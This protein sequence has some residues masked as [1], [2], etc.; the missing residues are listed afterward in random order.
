MTKWNNTVSNLK[1]KKD[2]RVGKVADLDG[3]KV[4]YVGKS[5]AYTITGDDCVVGVDTTSAAVTVTLDSDLVAAGRIIIVKDVGGN[6]ATNAI[7]IATEGSETIDGNATATISTAY[8][9]VRLISDG[10]NWF[11]F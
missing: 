10:T 9:V 6:A 1:V 8:G 11:T 4:K 3:V 5:A 2:L 7:T